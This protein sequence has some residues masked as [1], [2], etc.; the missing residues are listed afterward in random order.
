[1]KWGGIIFGVTLVLSL[2]AQYLSSYAFIGNLAFGIYMALNY[3]KIYIKDLVANGWKPA[4]HADEQILA[5]L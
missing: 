2:I 1:M 5:H 4:D 3:N